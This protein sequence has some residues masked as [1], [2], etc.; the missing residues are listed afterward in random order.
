MKNRFVIIT[1]LSVTLISLELVWTR[2]FSA[3]FF[4]SFAF[5][6]LSLAIMGLGVGALALRLFPACNKEKLLGLYLSLSGLMALVGPP[7]AFYIGV[8]YSQLFVSWAQVGK[9]ALTILLLSSAYFFGGMAL[10]LIFRH[11]HKDMPR[12]YMADLIGAALGTLVAI[13]FMNWFGTPWAVFLV[14]IPILLA[15]LISSRGALIAFP[16]LLFILMAILGTKAESLLQLDRPQRAPVIYTHWDA[17]AKVKIYDFG[18]YR[19]IEIDNAANSPILPF[20]GNWDKPEEEQ[21]QYNIPVDYL[22]KQFDSCV[23]LGL[24]SGAGSDV[25]QALQFGAKEVHAV[26]IN[27]HV[28]KMMLEGDPDGYILNDSITA[29]DI[30]TTHEFTGGLYDDPRVKVITEDARAYVRRHKNKFDVIF[31]LSSNSWAALAS[32]SFA[33]AENYLFTVEAF[34]DYWQAMTDSGFMMM[35]HQFYMPRLVGEVI[36]AL[37]NQGVEHPT[38]HFAVYDLPQLRRN[39][40]VIS[41]RPLDDSL[42]YHAIIDLTPEALG[43][44]N[45]LYPPADDS[46]AAR[47]VNRIVTLGWQ[48]MADSLPIDITPCTDNRP[49]TA[50]LGLWRNFSWEQLDKLKPYDFLSFPTSMFMMVVILAVVVVILIP[51][52]IIPYFISDKKLRALPWLYFFFIGMGFMVIEVILIQKYT[53]FIGAPIYSIATVLLT[54]LIASGIGSRFSE[55]FSIG[56]AIGVIIVWLLLDIFV[57][58]ALTKA[59]V[60]LSLFPRLIVTA[61]LIAPLGFFM[62]MPF[63]K[64]TKRVGELVDWGFAVNGAA[65]VF[66]ATGIMLVAFAHGFTLC[67]LIGGVCY[68]LALAS[69]KAKAAW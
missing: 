49:Y 11:N 45:L 50:Q 4:Y 56:T 69:F 7:L 2:I 67:L 51:L 37:E 61:I 63:P 34:E 3:E 43:Y 19:G 66:A 10:A 44:I 58:G 59:L 22:I 6:T 65:S 25:M 9:F 17:L 31:S 53:L 23:F 8:D 55:K 13:F 30:I 36:T 33:M 48:T 5:L 21:M 26:E 18:E 1:L 60:G 68:L 47:A 20:D 42:R 54:M 40:I 62:G 64:A 27:G 32:G 46:L 15:A 35:E 28:N 39:A 14:A 38:D 29:D 57:F 12:L 16:I 24:G 52:N 41:K